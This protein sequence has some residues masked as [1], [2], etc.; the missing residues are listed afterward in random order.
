MIVMLAGVR[1]RV[2]V[3]CTDRVTEPKPW[4]EAVML[5]VPRLTP[6]ICACCAG[7]VAP[8]AIVTLEGEIVTRAV[9]LLV[10]VIVT[11]PVGAGAASVT[12][13]E[14]DCPTP[15][16]TP[17][18]RPIPPALCTVTLA[19][20][21]TTLAALEL[22]V[23]TADPAA[24]PVTGTLTLVAPWGIVTELGTVAA[25]VL[26]ERSVIATPPAGAA[27]ER[28]SVAFCVAPAASPIVCGEKLRVAPT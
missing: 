11:P 19:V 7:C 10:S 27:A 17:V 24:T 8:A 18:G 3:T 1:L 16:V 20:A 9:L 26:L 2:P 28:L 15:T 12:G 23:M 14:V 5:A 22:A 4:A 13:N 6:V 21:L 25:A